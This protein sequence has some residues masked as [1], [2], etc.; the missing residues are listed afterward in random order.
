MR[1]Q[2]R[3]LHLTSYCDIDSWFLSF[4]ML[5]F[6]LGLAPPFQHIAQMFLD[7][8]GSNAKWPSAPMPGHNA[9]QLNIPVQQHGHCYSLPCWSWSAQKQEMR[10]RGGEFFP[11]C[12]HQRV[13]MSAAAWSVTVTCDW[14]TTAGNILSVSPCSLENLPNEVTFTRSAKPDLLNDPLV[15]FLEC[16]WGLTKTVGEERLRK[17][18]DWTTK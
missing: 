12:Y 18:H 14:K 17:G 11:R 2:T 16:F 3:H 8:K 7:P 15:A 5:L 13:V 6:V 1:I 9:S 10:H 4:L